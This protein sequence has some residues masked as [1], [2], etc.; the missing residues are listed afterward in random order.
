METSQVEYN[1]PI[2]VVLLR[3]CKYKHTIRITYTFIFPSEKWRMYLNVINR[4]IISDFL[5]FFKTL[6]ILTCVVA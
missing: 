3:S 1:M 6:K 5:S 2:K 4:K